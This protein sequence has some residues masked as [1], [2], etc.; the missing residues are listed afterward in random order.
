MDK[1]QIAQRANELTNAMRKFRRTNFITR[2]SS[3]LKNS[4]KHFLWLL[5]TLNNG[6][7]VMPSEVARK[8]EVTLAAIT[9]RINSL[10]KQ[11]YI[12]RSPSPDDRRVVF[13]S[14]SDKGTE[15]VDALK[16]SYWEKICGLVEYLGDK[17]SSDLIALIVKVSEYVKKT[18]GT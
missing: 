8:L 12:V 9:H 7:P 18:G 6:Q 17:D 16:K 14:L 5:A 4:E 2:D 13:I 10:E 11:G 15:M 1:E 3:G